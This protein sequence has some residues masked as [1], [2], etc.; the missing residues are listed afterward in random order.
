MN[1]WGSPKR[2]FIRYPFDQI[3]LLLWDLWSAEF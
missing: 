1:S 3:D 2:V